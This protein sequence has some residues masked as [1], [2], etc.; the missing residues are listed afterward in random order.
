MIAD[1]AISAVELRH[2][3]AVLQFDAF[4]KRRIRKGDRP[5]KPTRSKA[6]K[7]PSSS[8]ATDNLP[9]ITGIVKR[10]VWIEEISHWHDLH[11]EAVKA[12]Q[13]MRSVKNH[14]HKHA[15]PLIYKIPRPSAKST[16]QW[17][18]KSWRAGS[19]STKARAALRVRQICGRN[20]P[21]CRTTRFFSTRGRG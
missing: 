14:L 2:L 3:S 6:D 4:Q 1:D 11:F 10:I 18:P 15:S 16:A 5:P 19:K 12:S 13:L 17:Q 21:H 7:E 8:T 9:H 20:M